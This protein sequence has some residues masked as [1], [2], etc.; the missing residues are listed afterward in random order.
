MPRLAGPCERLRLRAEGGETS[1]V[2]W[3]L[4]LAE[5]EGRELLHH[6]CG[7]DQGDTSDGLRARPVHVLQFRS[8]CSGHDRDGVR[9][10]PLHSSECVRGVVRHEFN[11]RGHRLQHD[12][13]W[14]SHVELVP[15]ER[16]EGSQ[17]LLGALREAAP[18]DH[19]LAND[20]HHDDDRRQGWRCVGLLRS[21]A[22]RASC[23][24][25]SDCAHGCQHAH[26]VGM[27]TP[28]GVCRRCVQLK[29]TARLHKTH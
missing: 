4:E 13:E 29:A 17:L 3:C 28:A 8:R 26:F 11:V 6:G 16:A 15:L 20:Q 24:D 25:G 10:L 23:I 5:R 22:A 9:H 27:S 14:L 19:R 2:P 18:N 7:L 21:H 1:D 12:Q